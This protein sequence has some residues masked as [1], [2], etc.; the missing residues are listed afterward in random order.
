M[1]WFH[2]CDIKCILLL[3]Y[4]LGLHWYSATERF[5]PNMVMKLNSLQKKCREWHSRENV[6]P[7]ESWMIPQ[8]SVGIRIIPFCCW[9]VWNILAGWVS[10]WYIICTTQSSSAELQCTLRLRWPSN[11]YEAV[12]ITCPLKPQSC[13]SPPAELRHDSSFSEEALIGF[14]VGEGG[15]QGSN[16]SWW[17]RNPTQTPRGHLRKAI[18]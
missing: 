5:H 14:C 3:Y 9:Q 2:K 16:G 6:G 12:S 11:F 13:Y 17:T 1:F 8:L 7:R 10:H 15:L 4:S 18:H